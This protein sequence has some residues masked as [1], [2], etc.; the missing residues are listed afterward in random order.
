M[1]GRPDRTVVVVGTGTDV[2]KTW[3]TAALARVLAG[4]G[5]R[6]A[7]R[8]PVQSFAP[9]DPPE[10]RDAAVLGAATGEAPDLVC[11][12]HRSYEVP[13]APPMAAA[14]L[15]RPRI[16]LA[17]LLDELRW[18][19]GCA[20]GFVE[21]VGGVRSPISDDADGVALVEALA[22]D[23]VLLVADAGLGTVNLVRLTIAALAGRPLLTILNRFDAG[24]ALHRDNR[25]WLQGRDRLDVVTTVDELAG[26]LR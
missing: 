3:V 8:K 17:T 20:I 24:D 4:Q 19:E 26:R 6:V 23:L 1:P 25:A 5:V 2:G 21:T 18:P 11:P 16:A 10:G 9:E 7:A 15:G 13:L 12:P 22:P 14:A